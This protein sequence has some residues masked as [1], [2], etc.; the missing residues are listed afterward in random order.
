MGGSFEEWVVSGF[1]VFKFWDIGEL[2][3]IQKRTT[4]NLD[5]DWRKRDK[6][7]ETQLYTRLIRK[8]T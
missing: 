4:P 5:R 2:S 1:C 8:V 3:I 6:C 7:F